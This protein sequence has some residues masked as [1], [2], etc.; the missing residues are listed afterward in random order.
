M[1]KSSR[2]SAEKVPK[3]A[4]SFGREPAENRPVYRNGARLKKVNKRG[5]A[6]SLGDSAEK[7]PKLAE[8]S[9]REPADN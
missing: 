7:V 9:G 3:L 6:E 1:A 4:E 2:D 5:L 8:S